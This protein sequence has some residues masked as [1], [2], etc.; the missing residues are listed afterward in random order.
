MHQLSG[1]CIDRF[2]RF[3]LQRL[4][5]VETILMRN[6]CVL[7]F[8]KCALRSFDRTRRAPLHLSSAVIPHHY[9]QQSVRFY[10]RTSP[11]VDNSYWNLL[12]DGTAL[13]MAVAAIFIAQLNGVE[14]SL[15]RLI[16]AGFTATLAAMSSGG[17]PSAGVA[18][19]LASMGLP[20][21]DASLLLLAD[22]IL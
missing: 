8:P 15:S 1:T 2:Q 21:K 6:G 17:V 3:L 7:E 13:Y 4:S 14:M 12:E 9:A 11:S 22:R 10:A 18:L 20:I 16:E 5:R 19:V